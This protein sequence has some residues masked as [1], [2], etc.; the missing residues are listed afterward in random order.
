MPDMFQIPLL[1]CSRSFPPDE[2]QQFFGAALKD[3]F[4]RRMTAQ[5]RVTG[6]HPCLHLSFVA[7]EISQ[8]GFVDLA[9]YTHICGPIALKLGC[10]RDMA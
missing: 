3:Q 8:Q 9:L 2:L 5:L 1:A 10:Q 6:H 4:F 7:G